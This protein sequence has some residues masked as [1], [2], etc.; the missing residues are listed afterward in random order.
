MYELENVLLTVQQKHQL[1]SFFQSMISI[2]ETL[3]L[4]NNTKIQKHTIYSQMYIYMTCV[5][6]QR[7][8]N[9]L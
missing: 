5:L 8:N 3:F 2:I 6:Q 9:E 4:N 7:M 1:V